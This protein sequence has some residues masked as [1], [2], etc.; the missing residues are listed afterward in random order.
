MTIRRSLKKWQHRCRRR[1]NLA[2]SVPATAAE[3]VAHWGRG[4]PRRRLCVLVK[5]VLFDGL[6]F[7]DLARHLFLPGRKLG[8]AARYLLGGD[9]VGAA[10]HLLLNGSD[11]GSDP[12]DALPHRVDIERHSIE[13]LRIERRHRWQGQSDHGRRTF[14]AEGRAVQ[15]RGQRGDAVYLSNNGAWDRSR[16]PWFSP[17]YSCSL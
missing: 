7:R 6:Q 17:K 2:V 1:P 16:P 4:R 9:P 14:N 13:L 8:D 12:I 10:R 11:T 5:D 3:Q 15:A